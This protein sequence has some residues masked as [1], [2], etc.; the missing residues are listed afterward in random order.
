MYDRP[1][2][3]TKAKPIFPYDS[4]R[5]R[6]AQRAADLL[7]I[8]NPNVTQSVELDGVLKRCGLGGGIVSTSLKRECARGLRARKHIA[9]TDLPAIE[10]ENAKREKA[11]VKHQN[12]TRR[13]AKNRQNEENKLKLLHNQ[14]ATQIRDFEAS[15][16]ELNRLKSNKI[17]EAAVDRQR[18][19]SD[20]RK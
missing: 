11:L 1:T 15:V 16:K 8:E 14:T 7:A 18:S 9:D 17:V 3:A 10:G 6:F 12:E 2:M 20:G 4:E 5:D 13:I 19:E